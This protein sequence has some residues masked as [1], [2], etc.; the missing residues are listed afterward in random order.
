[1]GS[2]K[3]KSFLAKKKVAASDLVYKMRLIFYT[4]VENHLLLQQLGYSTYPNFSRIH[5]SSLCFAVVE[6]RTP[7]KIQTSLLICFQDH[8]YIHCEEKALFRGWH[9]I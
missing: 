9:L 5:G 6:A 8:H 1:M 2:G 4:Q 7:I 3:E